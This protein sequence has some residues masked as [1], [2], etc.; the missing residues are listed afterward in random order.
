[1]RRLP[2][3]EAHRKGKSPQSSISHALP[4]RNSSDS[5]AAQ[6]SSGS[7]NELAIPQGQGQGQ[8]QGNGHVAATGLLQKNQHV[9]DVLQRA[10]EKNGDDDWDGDF[11]DV[12]FSKLGRELR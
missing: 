4:G 2:I 9:S 12:S 11:D 7:I 6:P 3:P 5:L 10:K 8:G 1:M